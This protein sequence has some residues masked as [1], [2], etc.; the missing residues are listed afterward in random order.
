MPFVSLLFF[1]LLFSGTPAIAKEDKYRLAITQ[2]VEHPALNAVREGALETLK[3]KGYVEGDNLEVFYENAQGSIA[4]SAQIA[5]KLIGLN[6]DA[7]LAISTPSAQTIQKAAAGQFPIIFAAITDPYKANLIKES[8]TNLTGVVDKPPYEKQ[9]LFLRSL[10]P[11]L[12]RIG[13]LYN[14]GEENSRTALEDLCEIAKKMGLIL[15]PAPASK[16]SDIG[17]AAQSLVGQIDAF[18]LPTDNTVV[19]A[20]EAI[21]RVSKENKIPAFAADIMLVEQGLPGMI[22]YSYQDVGKAAGDMIVRVFEGEDIK[23][24]PVVHPQELKTVLNKKSLDFF[25]LKAEVKK[26]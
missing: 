2:I 20:L 4:T 5:K 23:N 16:S 9:L 22:G 24:I 12:K 3:K 8:E 17:S 14:P 25:D 11:S 7:I 26:E 10:L 18:Y 1:A 15:I 13:I 21:L 19:S 6:P